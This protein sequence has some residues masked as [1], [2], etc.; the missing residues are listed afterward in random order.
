MKQASVLN[1]S[2]ICYGCTRS[3]FPANTAAAS[4]F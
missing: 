2:V 4:S 1:Q 3:P